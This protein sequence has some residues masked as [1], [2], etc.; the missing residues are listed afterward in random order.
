MMA[1]RLTGA[2]KR[3]EEH[4]E[5]A[6]IRVYSLADLNDVLQ[7]HRHAWQLPKN[8]SRRKFLDFLL[9][10]TKLHVIGLSSETYGQITRY[11]WG[12][13]TPYAIGLSL[14]RNSYLSHGTAVLLHG[15]TEQIPKIVYVNHEQSTKPKPGRSLTQ[16]SIDRASVRLFE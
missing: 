9:E 4:F 8:T 13:T 10:R 6:S 3:I 12:E 7:Q 16:A 5:S 14:K 15:L 2:L 11:A 1:P